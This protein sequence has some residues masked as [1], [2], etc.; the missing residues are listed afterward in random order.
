VLGA[1]ERM[2]AASAELAT[3]APELARRLRLITDDH[4]FAP[5]K[6]PGSRWFAASTAQR[7]TLADSYKAAAAAS[8]AAMLSLTAL[9][10]G[11]QVLTPP[12]RSWTRPPACCRPARSAPPHRASL[13]RRR[14]PARPSGPD[15]LPV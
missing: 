12:A 13:P 14:P 3:Q 7:N 10:A 11:T 1:L 8:S 5:P 15:P 4:A 6:D 9:A 2:C